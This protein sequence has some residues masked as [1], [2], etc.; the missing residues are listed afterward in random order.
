M[1]T[2]ASIEKLRAAKSPV[3]SALALIGGKYKAIIVWHLAHDGVLRYSEL[4]RMLPQA[5]PKMLSQQLHELEGDGIVNRKLY[6]VVPP[7]TEYSLT[8][9]GRMFVPVV[10][11]MC[12]CGKEYHRRY[13]IPEPSPSKGRE[14]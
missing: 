5:A 2:P 3:E 4:Q 12:T 7:K 10:D 13:K 9:V 6:P 1:D 8:E 14:Q 11:A